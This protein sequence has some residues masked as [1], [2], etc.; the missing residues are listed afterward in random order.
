[1][2][3]DVTIWAVTPQLEVEVRALGR[4]DGPAVFLLHGWPDSARTWQGVAP[5]LADTGLRVL[6]P[7]LRGFGGTRF[8][9]QDRYLSIKTSP[10]T[11]L[12]PQAFR[13]SM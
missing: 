8:R 11:V 12:S 6:M 13:W 5:L 4:E 7:S 3:H 2:P 10:L 1:M 9:R